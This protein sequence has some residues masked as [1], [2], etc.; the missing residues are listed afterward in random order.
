MLQEAIIVAETGKNSK[1]LSTRF[2]KETR[3]AEKLIDQ[4]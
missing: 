4:N 1:A 2:E 3:L